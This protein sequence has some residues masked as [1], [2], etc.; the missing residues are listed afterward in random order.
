MI[1]KSLEK[2]RLFCVIEKGKILKN[3]TGYFK[4]QWDFYDLGGMDT[5]DE[6]EYKIRIKDS[7][8]VVFVFNGC[9]FLK[10]IKNYKEGG[11]ISSKLV[12]YVLPCYKDWKTNS[13]NLIFIATHA[14]MYNGTADKLREDIRNGLK[15]A[16]EDYKNKTG[17]IRYPYVSLF[18]D[19]NRFYAIDAT[20]KA[21]VHEIFGQIVNYTRDLGYNN[22]VSMRNLYK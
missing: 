2:S 14:D 22:G 8:N 10:E 13:K 6:N 4:G 16:N 5:N 9:D 21:K 11:P 3:I 17:D 12:H 20:D 7:R 15:S 19:D 18:D 1:T